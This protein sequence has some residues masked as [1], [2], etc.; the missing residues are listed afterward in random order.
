MQAIKLIKPVDGL[1]IEVVREVTKAT[2]ALGIKVF[3][4]GAQAKILWLEHLYQLNAGDSTRDIDFT[5]AVESWNQFDQIKQHLISTG[6]FSPSKGEMQR[7]LFKSAH[8]HHAF[9]VDIIPFG[10][11]QDAENNI[12]WPPDMAIVMNVSGYREAFNTSL[13]VA[14]DTDVQVNL[15]S[16]AG[17]AILKLLA[18]AERGQL[19]AHKDATDLLTLMRTYHAADNN[20]R[21]YGEVPQ[22]VMEN[23]SYHPEQ[24]GAWLLGY[25]VATL[26]EVETRSKM[27]R[28]LDSQKQ[29]LV[30]QMAKSL[31]ASEAPLEVAENLLS[32]FTKGVQQ[33][34]WSLS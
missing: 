24:M 30:V 34:K 32:S 1:T 9:I 26:A 11:V 29:Q 12:A 20:E 17:L 3:L 25:D 28:I 16:L 31:S 4:I 19:T 2:S 22:Q 27:M 5:F 10:G 18:W 21:M 7:L 6:M 33:R 23:V 15:V 13:L 14:L 8:M